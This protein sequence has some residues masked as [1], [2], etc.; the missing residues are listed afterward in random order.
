ML[1][2]YSNGNIMIDIFQVIV[3]FIRHHCREHHLLSISNHQYLKMHC[4]TPCFDAWSPNSSWTWSLRSHV[5]SPPSGRDLR[6]VGWSWYKRET[7]PA[8]SVRG[9]PMQKRPEKHN[10][11]PKK[12]NHISAGRKSLELRRPQSLRAVSQ[13][14][15]HPADCAQ[16]N[17]NKL[18]FLIRLNK[19]R[20]RRPSKI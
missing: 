9:N 10:N 5:D 11:H 14:E 8:H 12:G 1:R 6:C 13:L 18:G 17:R 19:T 7:A 4:C 3:L 15:W 20:A 16:R 2:F